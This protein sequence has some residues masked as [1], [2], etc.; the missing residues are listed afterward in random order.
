MSGGVC[1]S[2][3]KSEILVHFHPSA[4]RHFERAHMIAGDLDLLQPCLRE[5][6]SIRQERCKQWVLN[7]SEH[8]TN[9]LASWDCSVKYDSGSGRLDSGSL[10][11]GAL[12]SCRSCPPVHQINVI[13]AS[14]N[15]ESW[16]SARSP[17]LCCA[18]TCAR[19][20]PISPPIASE[21]SG[22]EAPRSLLSAGHEAEDNALHING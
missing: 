17:P 20:S 15:L 13:K 6:Q 5:E 7:E 8:L 21:T 10:Y 14:K 19:P 2:S 22:I 16:T 1:D 11:S 9:D 12:D 4:L 18:Q 3:K